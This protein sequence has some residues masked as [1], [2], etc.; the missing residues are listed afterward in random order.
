MRANWESVGPGERTEYVGLNSEHNDWGL[1]GFG[2]VLKL[3][4][5]RFLTLILRLRHHHRLL[6][7]K[8]EIVLSMVI[9]TDWSPRWLEVLLLSDRGLHFGNPQ[10]EWH[11]F[12]SSRILSATNQSRTFGANIWML[13][14]AHAS[15]NKYPS[16]SDF[17][18]RLGPK[19]RTAA[20][21]STILLS[22]CILDRL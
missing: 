14:I 20:S 12:F 22:L 2:G 5:A 4:F 19:R 1:F 10:L 3:A 8:R 7:G 18:L 11:S 13:R 16:R 21:G 6:P 17:G 15:L 9:S